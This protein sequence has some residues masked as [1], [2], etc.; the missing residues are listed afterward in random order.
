MPCCARF[1]DGALISAPRATFDVIFSPTGRVL[2]PVFLLL[3]VFLPSGGLGIDICLW[4]RLTH[5][6]CP[7]CGLTRSITN[8][9][10]GDLLRA[11]AYHP[12]GP[13]IWVIL[14]AVSVYSFLP[15][16]QRQVFSAAAVRNDGAIRGAYRL[17]VTTFV[18]FGLL[19]LG[20]EAL[21]KGGNLSF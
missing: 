5:L 2:A 18:V 14:V 19:R 10:H 9:T 20:L 1:L 16:R 13:V 3:S 8:M 21:A 12:F 7:G 11:A 4:H 15:S 17:F 6:D